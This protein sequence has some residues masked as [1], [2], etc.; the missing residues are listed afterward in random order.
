M[1]LSGHSPDRVTIGPPELSNV[2]YLHDLNDCYFKQCKSE[3]S[4]PIAIQPHPY[5]GQRNLMI[6]NV[7][8]LKKNK[9]I[10]DASKHGL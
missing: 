3:M 10:H 8:I 9:R 5:Q 1:L 4:V 7:I 6:F 2:I